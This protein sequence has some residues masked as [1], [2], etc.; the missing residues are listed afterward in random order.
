MQIHSQH[1]IC[2]GRHDHIGHQLCRNRVSRLGLPVLAGIAEIGN[3][4]GDPAGR[5]ALERVDHHQHFH[6]VVIYGV[7]GGLNDEHVASA[8]TLIQRS[9]A[10]TIGKF[11]D[12]R[13]AQFRVQMLADLLRQ[14]AIGVTS[15]D[16]DVLTMCN[17]SKVPLFFIFGILIGWFW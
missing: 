17:H 1:A 13:V 14:H 16:L 5:G 3:H 12:L 15:K 8:D 2:A 10:L 11:A 9:I 7:A 6:Q 4:G